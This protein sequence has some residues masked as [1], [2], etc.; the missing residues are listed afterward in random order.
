MEVLLVMFRPGCLKIAESF[1][2]DQQLGSYSRF[3]TPFQFL[4][5]GNHISGKERSVFYLPRNGFHPEAHTV[6]APETKAEGSFTVFHVWNRS[7]SSYIS[8]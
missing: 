3:Q 1:G 2:E 6:F 8:M 5:L 4:K 7:V